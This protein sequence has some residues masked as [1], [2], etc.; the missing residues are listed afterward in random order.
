MLTKVDLCHAVHYHSMTLCK[1]QQHQMCRHIKPLVV[2]MADIGI[3]DD[4]ALQ[5]PDSADSA[6]ARAQR[7]YR[8][9]QKVSSTL[10]AAFAEVFKDARPRL[11]PIYDH[12]KVHLLLVQWDRLHQKLE[13]IEVRPSLS[14]ASRGPA[15][16]WQSCGA[17]GLK[18]AVN[19]HG[20]E[21]RG[22]APSVD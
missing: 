14:H 9:R 11:L 12:R 17:S 15:L 10:G 3:N 8:I 19:M 1:G 21:Q 22:R 13:L 7:A 18:S 2:D 4:V 6:V 20:R 5:S 16:S